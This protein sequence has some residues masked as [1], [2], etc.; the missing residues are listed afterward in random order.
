[1]LQY[2]AGTRR[3]FGQGA[4]PGCRTYPTADLCATMGAAPVNPFSFLKEIVTDP[5]ELAGV[6]LPSA[7]L[8]AGVFTYREADLHGPA[9]A[10]RS[11]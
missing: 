2:E 10:A 7:A 6:T 11:D 5:I 1:V 3:A 9:T 8:V 4:W